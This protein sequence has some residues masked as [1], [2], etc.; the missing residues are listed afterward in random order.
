MNLSGKGNFKRKGSL[1]DNMRVSHCLK[2]LAFFSK[3]P[4][5]LSAFFLA[6]S[7][8]KQLVNSLH[9]D[10]SSFQLSV[11]HDAPG[12]SAQYISYFE[13]TRPIGKGERGVPLSHI[14]GHAIFGVKVYVY[15]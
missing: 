10:R 14:R 12:T 15:A 8:M 6:A 4:K 5:D 9:S 1:T 7:L 2:F 11:A 3:V 13:I